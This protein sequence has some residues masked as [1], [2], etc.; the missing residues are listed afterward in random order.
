MY[1]SSMI[2]AGRSTHFKIL[3]TSLI[4]ATIISIIA[5]NARVA[6]PTGRVEL[7]IVKAG[8]LGTFASTGTFLSRAAGPF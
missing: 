8:K 6:P 3:V 2:T 5:V 4:C 1:N 7:T